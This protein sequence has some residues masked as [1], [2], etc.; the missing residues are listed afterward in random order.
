MDPNMVLIW[1]S[2]P[3]VGIV[4]AVVKT[5]EKWL[6]KLRALPRLQ[7][8]GV[9]VLLGFAVS[10]G[11]SKPQPPGPTKSNLKYLLAERA[12]LSNG[13]SFGPKAAVVTASINATQAANSV[14]NSID[15]EAYVLAAIADAKDDA[16]DI[17]ALPRYY[18]RLVS[19]SPTVTNQTLYAEIKQI[20]VTE[21]VAEAAVWFNVIPNSEPTMRFNYA[22]DTAT[23][24]Y[25]TAIP[26]GSTFP[27]TFAVGGK[28]CYLYY[29]AVPG[30]TP[31]TLAGSGS[32]VQ[33]EK[34]VAFGSPET[35]EPFDILGGLA[36][37]ED[38]E[39]WVAVT[40]Y[41]TNDVGQVFYFDNGRLANPPSNLQGEAP[42]NEEM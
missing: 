26:S 29:F 16:T 37:Y 40:G 35:G 3:L 12:R 41:R 36:I 42:P 28:D 8:V 21:G 19:Q 23:N 10:W 33:W 5:A 39:Y 4:I 24:L 7:Q 31:E 25:F 30:W 17:E 11:G 14:T 9:L 38:G 6:P 27:D 20:S 34:R 1:C 32:P 22:L 15:D 18:L 2:I 13:Q